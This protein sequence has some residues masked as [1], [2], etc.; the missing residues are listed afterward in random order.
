MSISLY[1]FDFDGTLVEK[2]HTPSFEPSLGDE[3]EAA[4]R[5]GSAW[6]INTGR[7]L[8]HTLEGVLGHGLPQAPDF[9][10]ARE[11][12]IYARTEAGRWADLGVWN[13]D[14]RRQHDTFY[15][16]HRRVLDEVRAFVEGGGLGWWIEEAG[17]PA[18]VI[19]HTEQGMAT[20][21]DFVHEHLAHWPDLGY[22]RNT[23]YLRFTHR[24]FDKG[25]A[26]R[27][28]SRHL[29]LT[30]AE[31]FAAG[32]NFNDLPMLRR[33]V[34][35]HLVAPV[36]SLPEVKSQVEAEGGHLSPLP[37]SRAMAEAVAR[38]RRG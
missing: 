16:H 22:Q 2:G 25:T 28:L 38:L 11:H 29:G 26:L 1:C 14:A 8:H 7:S 36:N 27:E 37:A 9:I 3:L 31:V 32:D 17:D 34:A 21:I 23:I 15:R 13:R 18:G 4:R 33:E 10:I 5:A 35:Q 19:T 20:V 6:V 24:N 12:E 30:P